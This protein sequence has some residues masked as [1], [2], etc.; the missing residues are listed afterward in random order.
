LTRMKNAGWL[1]YRWEESK[2]GPPRK[3]YRLT[4]LG[5]E[6]LSDLDQEWLAFTEAVASLSR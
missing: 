6:I 4:E 5:Q 2:S 3:Y 1:D